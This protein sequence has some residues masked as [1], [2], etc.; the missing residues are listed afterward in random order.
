[1]T[2]FLLLS[3]CH[4]RQRCNLQVITMRGIFYFLVT[5]VMN[6]LT[7]GPNGRCSVFEIERLRFS[8]V[9]PCLNVFFYWPLF[10]VGGARLQ[11]GK[12]FE[13]G[14]FHTDYNDIP[15]P[16]PTWGDF[17]RCLGWSYLNWITLGISSCF[18]KREDA[19]AVL[20]RS[21][22][23]R[24]TIDE[25]VQARRETINSLRMELFPT[26][27]PDPDHGRLVTEEEEEFGSDE[28]LR[29]RIFLL[30]QR[31][32]NGTNAKGDAAT[33]NQCYKELEI[34]RRVSRLLRGLKS[35]A[36]P[37]LSTS[38]LQGYPSSAHP[39]AGAVPNGMYMV[40]VQMAD[41][42][43]MLQPYYAGPTHSEGY[44]P[45]AAQPCNPAPP[46]LDGL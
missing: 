3:S 37:N 34:S 31:K 23:P 20:T 17:F 35:D 26:A 45:A 9:V 41:G 24:K 19:D 15:L 28:F 12:K 25:I 10:P 18:T 2:M 8:L 46:N 4:T 22:I 13:R 6:F 36:P 44:P 21:G 7:V 27:Q 11:V 33:L 5:F 43:A 38:M 16:Q 1:M 42:T 40:P 30:E 29:I 39:Y 14:C 32:R